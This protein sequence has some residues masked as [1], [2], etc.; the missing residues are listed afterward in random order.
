MTRLRGLLWG[1]W[2]RG[3][4][5]MMQERRWWMGLKRRLRLRGWVSLGRVGREYLAAVSTLGVLMRV[6]IRPSVGLAACLLLLIVML[7]LVLMLKLLMLML[8][9]VLM[10]KLLMLMLLLMKM[11]ML[12]LLMPLLLPWLLIL[13]LILMLLLM[14]MMMMILILLLVMMMMILCM[15][16]FLRLLLRL[17]LHAFSRRMMLPT[18]I[19]ILFLSPHRV[20]ILSLLLRWRGLHSLASHDLLQH[21]VRFAVPSVSRQ[22][23]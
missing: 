12:V 9:L 11:K 17:L 7:L 6:G 3:L 4:L 5:V 10:L 21:F 16:A 22:G 18:C 20:I 23:W 14:M 19:R 8:L 1:R 15:L 2:R 13:M